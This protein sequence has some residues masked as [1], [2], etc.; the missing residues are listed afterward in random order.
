MQS[1]CLDP[2]SSRDLQ[3]QP[4]ENNRPPLRRGASLKRNPGSEILGCANSDWGVLIFTEIQ[5]A[6]NPRGRLFCT[7]IFGRFAPVFVDFTSKNCRILKIS[8]TEM[9][10]FWALRAQIGVRLFSQDFQNLKC[11]GVR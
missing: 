2:N 3:Y 1:V 9:S 7:K 6:E 11:F 4:I 5:I 10:I 8:N